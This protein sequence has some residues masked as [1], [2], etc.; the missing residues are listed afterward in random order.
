[1][2]N[3]FNVRVDKPDVE[4]LMQG[5]A[6]RLQRFEMGEGSDDEVATFS[7]YPI[8][9][10]DHDAERNLELL[11]AQWDIDGQEIIHSNRPVL[12]P[13]I[14]AFQKVVRRWSWWF[15]NP[16]IDQVSQFNHTAARVIYSLYRQ[17][18]DTTQQLGEMA[19]RL[20][21]AES[22]ISEMTKRIEELE[23]VQ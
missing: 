10:E 18:R 15:L 11:I 20:E 14:I 4:L 16:I 1:M 3:I 7:L 22:T 2:T 13:A 5:V 9:W 17:Q 6:E 12:G 23:K 8:G 19:A 21:A